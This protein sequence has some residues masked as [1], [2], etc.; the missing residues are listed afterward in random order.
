MKKNTKLIS[1]PG[2]LSFVVVRGQSTVEMSSPHGKQTITR[3]DCAAILRGLRA[4][5]SHTATVPS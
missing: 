4:A 3:K 1:L 2:Q 5:R